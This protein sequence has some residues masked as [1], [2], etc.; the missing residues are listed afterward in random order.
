[1]DRNPVIAFTELLCSRI[2]G[3]RGRRRRAEREL[4]GEGI[5]VRFREEDGPQSK[6]PNRVPRTEPGQERAKL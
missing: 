2:V 1:M 3:D 6:A 4:A 5:E